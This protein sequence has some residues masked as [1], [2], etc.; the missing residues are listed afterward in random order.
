MSEGEINRWVR[1]NS[2]LLLSKYYVNTFLVNWDIAYK[3]T[4]DFILQQ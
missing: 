1:R 2:D 3:V 4:R